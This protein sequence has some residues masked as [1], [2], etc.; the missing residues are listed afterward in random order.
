[1]KD[2][3]NILKV[4]QSEG[5][6]EV[7]MEEFLR[8]ISN[9]VMVSKAWGYFERNRDQLYPAMVGYVESELLGTKYHFGPFKKAQLTPLHNR[10]L[11]S[12]VTRFLDGSP[13]VEFTPNTLSSYEET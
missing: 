2:A 12:A 9:R 11:L 10:V 13:E 7:L 5:F 3:D 6:K 1:M 8:A 4:I